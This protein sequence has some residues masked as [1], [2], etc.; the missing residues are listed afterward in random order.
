MLAPR[1]RATAAAAPTLPPGAARHRPSSP[2]SGQSADMP[3]AR[4]AA[5][6]MPWLRGGLLPGPAASSLPDARACRAA[7]GPSAAVAG[8]A[9][10]RVVSCR[11]ASSLQPCTPIAVSA[12]SGAQQAPQPRS[13]NLPPPSPA[14]QRRRACRPARG[15]T[16]GPQQWAAM[17]TTQPQLPREPR[18]RRRPRHWSCVSRLVG[19]GWP[20]RGVRCTLDLAAAQGALGWICG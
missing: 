9:G 13:A 7:Y 18:R 2:S 11:A 16:Q 4:T 15:P 1:S 5:M 3:L 20:Q 19:R 10:I 8:A 12:L 6:I 17:S 14:P